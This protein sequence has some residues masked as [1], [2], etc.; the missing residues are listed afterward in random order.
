MA[1]KSFP[2]R[3]D[4]RLYEELRRWAEAELRSVNAQIEYLLKRAIEE[5]KRGRREPPRGAR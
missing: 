3:V 5:R 2:L 1:R 4:P